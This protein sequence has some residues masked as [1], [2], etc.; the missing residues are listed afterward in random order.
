M[1]DWVASKWKILPVYIPT[2]SRVMNSSYNFHFLCQEDLEKILRSPWVC[3]RGFLSLH[4]WYIAF[5]PF[6]DIPRNKLI[7]VKLPGLLIEFQ[8]RKVF[9]EIGNPIGKFIY[10]DPK[11]LGAKDKRVAQILIERGYTGGFPE[12][13]EL[14][15]DKT[16]IHQQLDFWCIP[17]HCLIFHCMRHLMA[18]CPRKQWRKQKRTEEAQTRSTTGQA[19]FQS[20]RGGTA[21]TG[22]YIDHH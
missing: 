7:W 13:I 6:R 16:H 10:V 2:I 8:T 5:N 19:E 14:V 18:Q 15:W 17:F 3:R 1:R 20:H 22:W 12:H 9:I 21:D 4:P 11:C